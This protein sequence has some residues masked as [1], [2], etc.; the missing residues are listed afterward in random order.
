MRCKQVYWCF[1]AGALATAVI[2]GSLSAYAQDSFQAGLD[3]YLSGEYEEALQLWKPAAN[4]GN[5]VAAFNVGVLYARGFGVQADPAEALR[6][7]RRSASAGYA[8]AQFNLGAAYYKGEGT[9]V[10]VGQAVFWWEKAVDQ[11]HPDALYNLGLLYK[12][13]KMVERDV[14]RAV[15]LFEKGALLGDARA[16]QTLT[17]LKENPPPGEKDVAE[18]VVEGRALRTAPSERRSDWPASEDPKH[19]AVQ[20]FAA[21]KRQAARRFAD[22]HG[23]SRDIR[24]YQAEVDGKT[25]FKGVHGSFA[26]KKAARAARAE[27]EKKMPGSSLW[28]RR[29]RSIQ[30]EA[31]VGRGSVPPD[32]PE[33]S[34][35]TSVP[36]NRRAA[37]PEKVSAETKAAP[38]A[39]DG[40][41]RE[42]VLSNTS[43]G[44]DRRSAPVE[45]PSMTETATTD[46]ANLRGGRQSFDSRDYEAAFGA[47]RPLAEKGIPD[48]QY[49]VGV[50]YENGQ[51]V[52]RD[53]S[54]AFHWYQL[55]AQRGHAKSQFNLGMLYRKGQGVAQNDALGVYWIQSA[56]DRGDERALSYLKNLN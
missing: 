31:V 37:E 42:T 48:A 35:E 41:K 50:M 6:W 14:E 45:A 38:A 44:N 25:W 12:Q 51:G 36:E 13:G 28:L 29:Y 26:S 15:A 4:S 47:W 27:L 55:A 40:S 8:N 3:A 53:Y 54:K 24:V 18:E 30:A 46:R 2:A 19:W 33:R 56:A 10:N 20:V 23:L 21:A 49:G 39:D 1:K 11:D 7:Y 43:D 16:T 32:K 17:E 5:R 9:Q 22:E 52:Q 34:G